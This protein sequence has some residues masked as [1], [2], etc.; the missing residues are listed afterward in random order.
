MT[1]DATAG[2]S[3]SVHGPLR[4]GTAGWAIRKTHAAAFP[5]EGTHLQRYSRVLSCVEINSSFYQPHATPVYEKWA[6]QTPD[7]FRF[8]VKIPR[9]ITHGKRLQIGDGDIG[10]FLQQAAGL[11]GKL[12]ALLLQLPPSLTFDEPVAATFFDLLRSRY[13][14]G[15][16][17]EPR[18]SSWFSDGA[19]RLLQRFFIGRAAADPGVVSAASSAGGYRTITE[20]APSAVVYFRLHGFPRMYWS[21]Y[22]EPELA[23][24]D[25]AIRA[26]ATGSELWCIF[27]NTAD[28]AA[29]DNA[30]ELAAM[31]NRRELSPM[32][33]SSLPG[34]Q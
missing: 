9:T 6:R 3:L 28:G 20:N 19:D 11:G 31:D 4:V 8:S 10:A 27:D 12:G 15:V 23:A 30:L 21:R 7:D 17:C 1:T 25:L 2:T 26:N 14:G 24:W 5:G 32:A 18:H 13:A 33:G 34:C 29:I 22:S 16:V